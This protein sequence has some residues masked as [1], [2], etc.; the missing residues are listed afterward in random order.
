MQTTKITLHLEIEVEVTGNYYKGTTGT[1]YAS[2]G[3]PGEPPEAPEFDIRNVYWQG[4][5]I[6]ALLE[7]E[8]VDFGSIESDCL[9]NL[10]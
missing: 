10:H 2:N 6:T 5:D 1:L 4:V 8:K 3:D 9:D 7:K